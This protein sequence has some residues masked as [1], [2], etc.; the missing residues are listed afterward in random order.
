M[1]F[2]HGHCPIRPAR[3][4]APALAG[5][6]LCALP[7]VGEAGG[8]DRGPEGVRIAQGESPE[9]FCDG[10]D[11]LALRWVRVDLDGLD[12]WVGYDL[13]EVTRPLSYAALPQEREVSLAVRLLLG[14]VGADRLLEN[15]HGITESVGILY[16]VDNRR[17]RALWNPLDARVRPFDG[18]GEGAS[19][20]SCA[21]R[22]QYTGMGT[23]RALD[24]H[25]RYEPA[26][27]ERAA[28]VAVAAW[29]LQETGVHEDFTGG[30]TNYVHRCGGSA[31]GRSTYHCDGTGT[32]GIVDLPGA[33]PHAGPT[34]FRAPASV[35]PAGYYRLKRVA[36]VDY[37]AQA[38]TAL[39][40]AVA[41]WSG[42]TAWTD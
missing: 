10:E 20:A 27:V 19:F 36:W 28:D 3:W 14:E 33:K 25:A 7:T 18:C 1:A 2:L 5:A 37:E 40:D 8:V 23:W 26:L 34:L 16:T 41:P 42:A 29:L 32:K 38:R 15:R 30:A 4:R 12:A 21:N 6:L 31:Y 11:C 35:A 22:A 17:V 39:D 13:D 24:P 9:A